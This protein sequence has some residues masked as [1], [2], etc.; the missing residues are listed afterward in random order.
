MP[1]SSTVCELKHQG[2]IL[3]ARQCI[4][5]DRSI[6]MELSFKAPPGPDSTKPLKQVAEEA[7]TQIEQMV[8][9][10]ESKRAGGAWLLVHMP[11][12]PCWS[13]DAWLLSF[14]C[15]TPPYSTGEGDT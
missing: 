2:R 9:A 14:L 1:L 7:T 15:L 4:P 12:E 3:T 11:S 10:I 8:A 5:T 6:P 13:Q